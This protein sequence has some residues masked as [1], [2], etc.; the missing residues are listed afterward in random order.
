MQAADN[1]MFK[2]SLRSG[3]AGK[4]DFDYAQTA[5]HNKQCRSQQRWREELLSWLKA[6]VIRCVTSER[7]SILAFIQSSC[8]LIQPGTNILRRKTM[9]Q[10]V[11]IQ[12]VS[13]R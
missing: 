9:R 5:A 8:L 1:A 11:S 13:M 2:Q 6:Q 3:T 4:A 7:L 10:F 12:T